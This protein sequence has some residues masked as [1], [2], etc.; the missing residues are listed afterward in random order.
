LRSSPLSPYTTL[1]RSLVPAEVL[2]TGAVADPRRGTARVAPALPRRPGSL[3]LC[4]RAGRAAAVR[5]HPVGA[6]AGD[7]ARHRGPRLPPPRS[8]EHTSELQSRENL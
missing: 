1:F 8:E 3:R 2:R 4:A 5:T 7:R 6:V